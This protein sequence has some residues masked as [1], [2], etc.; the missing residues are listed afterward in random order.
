[1]QDKSYDEDYAVGSD[2]VPAM[3]LSLSAE[4]DLWGFSSSTWYR[5]PDGQS[6]YSAV[7]IGYS[8]LFSYNDS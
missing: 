3:R 8:E 7:E 2:L 4:G 1:V 5:G 6:N